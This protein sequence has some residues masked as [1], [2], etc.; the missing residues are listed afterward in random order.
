MPKIKTFAERRKSGEDA[1]ADEPE[2]F[3]KYAFEYDKNIKN[4]R[5]FEDALIKAFG[6]NRGERISKWFSPKII[7]DLFEEKVCKD[8][9]REN[10]YE[11]EKGELEGKNIRLKE[12]N[13]LSETEIEN[14][15]EKEADKRIKKMY[16]EERRGE[17]EVQRETPI[18]EII[19]PKQIS[20][21]YTPKKIS[22]KSYKRK[23]ISVKSYNKGYQKWT[24]AQ[25]TFL[26]VRKAKKISPKIIIQQYNSHFKEGR[27]SSSL[28]T[29]IFR[30]K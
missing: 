30:T 22:I 5:D 17:Y 4:Y 1:I 20:V 18:G 23:G 9:I 7:A 10:I 8:K 28:K 26:A 16:E 15:A 19:K 14:L 11:E 21:I 27:S 6:D 3:I 2:R 12:E 24:P 13:K 25:K 29:Q